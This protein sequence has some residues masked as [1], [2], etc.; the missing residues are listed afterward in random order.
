MQADED[1]TVVFGHQHA[2]Y[3]AQPMQAEAEAG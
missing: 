2:F 3:W 1:K